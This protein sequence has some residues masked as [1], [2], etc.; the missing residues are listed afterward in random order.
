MK[1]QIVYNPAGVQQFLDYL[2]ERGAEMIELT[3]EWEVARYRLPG[4]NTQVVY[5][6]KPKSYDGGRQHLSFSSDA[7]YFH[8]TKRPQQ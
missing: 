2:E 3:N 1:S 8:Y 4:E 5:K 6:T 7:S